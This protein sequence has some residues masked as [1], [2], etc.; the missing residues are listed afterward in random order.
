M[1]DAEQVPEKSRA[2]VIVSFLHVGPDTEL[3]RIMC[4]SVRR[5]MPDAT[6]LHMTD[7]ATPVI[8]GCERQE[9]LYDGERLMTYRLQHLAIPGDEMVIL[10]T[11]ITV[12]SDLSPVMQ[13][14]FDVALTKRTGVILYEGRDIVEMMPYNTGVMFSKCPAFWRECAE[15]CARAPEAI[16]RWW[17]DQVSVRLAADSGRYRILE[18][19]VD[20][21][22]YTPEYEHEDM[23]MRHVVHWKG[24][25]PRKEW[26]KRRESRYLRQSET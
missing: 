10:D 6:L 14:S 5:T 24:A 18:L 2:E 4:A 16:Q 1:P 23:S 25:G 11:D 22:N 9:L 13:K 12:Q 21:F 7:S 19:P 20:T 15:S 3:A 26:M 8:D 17:G